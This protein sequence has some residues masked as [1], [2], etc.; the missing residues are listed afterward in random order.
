VSAPPLAVTV[1]PTTD[2]AFTA[3]VKALQERLGSRRAYA[4]LEARGGWASTITP[5]LGRFIAARD[6]FYL[7]T[8]NADGQPYVQHR[9]GPKGF[10]KALDERTLVFADYSGNRQYLTVGNLAENPKAFL[11]LMDYATRTRIKIWGT[12]RVVDDDPQLLARLAP[13]GAQ[14]RAERAI[15]FEIAAWDANCQQHI[16]RKY[17][18]EAVDAL[19]AELRATIARLEQENAALRSRGSD[20][21]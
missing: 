17:D 19:V 6:S 16:P 8:A 10:L 18:A 11:F 7:A 5:E 4:R 13:A 1:R 21:A 12:A 3:S 20:P 14:A 15:L 9:G 2:V